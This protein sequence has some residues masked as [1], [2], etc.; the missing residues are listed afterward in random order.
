MH[1]ISSDDLSREQI[2]HIF[3]MADNINEGKEEISLKEHSTLAL[4][5]ES[6]STR[7][8]LSFEVAMAHLGG[9][10]IFMDVQTSQMNRGETIGDTAKILSSYCD[11]IAARLFKHTDIVEMAANS[12]VPVINAETGLEHPTQA[13]AD[14]YTIMQ[15]FDSIKDIKIAFMGDI[16][17][18]TD[19]S[20]MLTAAKLGAEVALVGPEDTIP[21][22]RTYF[23]HAR[24]YSKVHSYSSVEEGLEDADIV[25]MDT[26]MSVGVPQTEADKRKKVLAPYQ[27]NAKALSHASDKALV[28]HCLP[29]HR[30]EEITADVIDGP[31]SI[32]WEQAKNKLLLN[33]AIILYLSEKE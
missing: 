18:N 23:N 30:G 17:T 33:K 1:L 3:E 32:V 8:R 25:Y 5:F 6:P 19:N 16:A 11:F 26:F 29:A 31:R 22:N 14:V 13:L 27:L 4:L 24:E 21:P 15:H 12:I 28:M 7:T 20:L 9:L 2:N 10:A